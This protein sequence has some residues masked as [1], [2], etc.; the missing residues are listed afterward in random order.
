MHLKEGELRA[1][2]D[3]ELHGPALERVQ[4][5]LAACPACRE[6]GSALLAR[7][8]GVSE[9]L[10]TLNPRPHEVELPAG[11]A[12]A[13]LTRRMYTD[14]K[15]K[16]TMP[17]K[18]F[19]RPYRPAWAVLGVVAL[20]A[21]SMAF[22]PVRALAQS[23]LGLFRVQ[24]VQVVP[25]NP[26][27]LPEQLGSSSQ[28]EAM[29]AEDMTV[30]GGGE[31]QSAAS[32]GEAG[33]LAGIAV[34]LPEGQDPVKLG[35]RPGGRATFTVALDRARAILDEIGR[36][37]I[38]LPA[39]L[40]GATVTVEMPAG[41]LAQYG[42]CEYDLETLRRHA[43][44]PHGPKDTR[45][46][47]CTSLMQ[48]PS[49]TINA[50]EGLDIAAIGQA[51]LQVLG[52]NAEEAQSFAGNIDWATTLVLPI[53]R[54]GTEYSEVSVD[55]VTGTLI[56]HDRARHSEQYMLIWVK[57]EIVYALTGPGDAST[58]LSLAGTLK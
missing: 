26:G 58:A 41:V 44:D 2:H 22:Q 12:R 23:F 18:I 32:A 9:R 49:P 36:S 6:R 47:E 38:T 55:G 51:F 24:Q 11:A 1:F 28:L 52:M 10:S 37:D 35:V 46:P 48:M 45:L 13:R 54:Y 50:P 57:D 7:A 16:T 4:A 17:G 43:N 30:E 29:F 5:H 15:E 3:H 39:E 20:L 8:Q 27:N 34:R 56:L 33:Q 53:P 40:D 42:N 14:E 19:S 21:V 25:V 31:L